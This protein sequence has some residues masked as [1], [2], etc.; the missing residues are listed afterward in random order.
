MRLLHIGDLHLGKYLLETPLLDD[1]RYVL[2]AVIRAADENSVDAVLIAGDIYDRSVPPA[3]AVGVLD[4]FICEL[5][6][7]NIAVF[8][9]AGNHDSPERLDFGSRLF[10]GRGVYITGYYNGQ[11]R[12][13]ALNDEYGKVNFYLLPFLKPAMVRSFF[14]DDINTTQDAVY[15]ALSGSPIDQNER[16][17]LIAHQF[18]CAGEQ[19]PETCESETISIGGSDSVDASCF[20]GFDYVALGHLHRSQ[21]IGRESVR[22]AGSPLKYSLSEVRHIKSFTLVTLGEKG[23]VEAELIPISPPHDLRK[24]TGKLDELISAARLSPSGSGDYIHAVLTDDKAIDPAARLR[25]VYPNLLHVE[26]NR[27]GR[28]VYNKIDS[29]TM[30]HKSESELFEDFYL[31][32]HGIGLTDEQREIFNEVFANIKGD[33]EP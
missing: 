3:D 16:N 31:H 11:L 9:V 10:S 25:M 24:I 14:D 21:Y 2:E 23:Q 19:S 13:A 1:Q 12:Q 28:A 26:I 22:Y 33:E 18:V 4:D 8:A 5:S 7:R 32:I 17:V 30:E 27:E 20:D 15:A 29:D 6:S